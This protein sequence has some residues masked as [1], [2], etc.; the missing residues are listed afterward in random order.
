MHEILN[1]I[2]HIPPI[3]IIFTIF[4]VFA[5]SRVFIKF[6]TKNMNAKEFIFWS[7]VWISAL[8]VVYIPGKTDVLAKVMG[9][10]RGFDAVTFLSVISLFYIIYRLYVK[11][12]EHDQVIT[13]LVRQIALKNATNKKKVSKKRRI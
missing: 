12:N 6:R 2:I 13:A 9:M 3:R 4:A 10:G 8:A 7:A 5:W 1:F 11:S